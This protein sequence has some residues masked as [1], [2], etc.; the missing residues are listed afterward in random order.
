MFCTKCGTQNSETNTHCVNCGAELIPPMGGY[1][2]TQQPMGGYANTR[3]P[4]GGYTNT[5]QPMGGYTNTQQPMGGYTNTQQPFYG[6]TTTQQPLK[7]AGSKPVGLYI[8]GGIIAVISFILVFIP[9]FVYNFKAYNP[10]SFAIESF[11]TS[12]LVRSS[13]SNY[14]ALGVLVIIFFI[15]PMAF[16]IVWAI[17]SFMM[18]KPAGVFGII[19]SSLYFVTTCFWSVI[20]LAGVS[21]RG[22]LTPVVFF[23]YIFAIA[24]IPISIV[25][26]VKKKY[27]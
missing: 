19:A 26:I 23:M 6:Y 4:M 12:G 3:Q 21:S 27:L 1:T 5:Q 20:S 2:N 10:F 11:Q 22:S 16:Q 9:S 14:V 25:Q 8:V 15:I 24:G 17:L 13:S 7:P 18:R